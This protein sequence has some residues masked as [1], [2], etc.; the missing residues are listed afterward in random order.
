MAAKSKTATQGKAAA[1]G[2]VA[3]KVR[4]R[5]KGLQLTTAQAAA[6]N[7]AFN[8]TAQRL[9]NAARI[10]AFATG[11]R[12]YRLQAANSTVR[13]YNVYRANA[14]AAAVAAHAASMS[15]RQSK[16]AHQNAA[17]VQRIGADAFR[18]TTL[19]GRAQFAQA[20]V[21]A[22]AHAAVMHTITQKQ[23][24]AIETKF[25]NKVVKTAKKAAGRKRGRPKGTPLS[26][27]I[28]RAATR[29]GQQA[30]AK[31]PGTRGR[32]KG[33]G[34][35]G[36][37][38]AKAKA[39]NIKTNQA[40]AAS[41]K[42]AA[43][44]AAKTRTAP[45]NWAMAAAAHAQAMYSGHAA[46]NSPPSQKSL[47]DI[48]WVG[49]EITPNCVIVAIANHLLWAKQVRVDD[50]DLKELAME[51]PE[52]PTI[53]EVLWHC[54]KT[55]WPASHRGRLVDYREITDDLERE[56][57]VVGYDAMTDDGWQ[58]HCALSRPRSRVVSWGKERDRESLVE[59]AWELTWQ[60]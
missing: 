27:A 57:V 12:K 51:V 52:E 59:E 10:R 54:W 1:K 45:V 41:S 46:V 36:A 4:G 55:G 26:K 35:G 49:D 17:L 18:H 13:Q 39:Q 43:P 15:L 50:N 40:A 21:K 11:L 16:L 38:T 19:L 29:A 20:G 23:A 56:G 31:V 30:A 22:Y 42:K 9:A 60:L 37:T 25:L 5:P 32:P 24:V 44:K 2:K 14:Q 28:A 7:K 33:S 47:L 3:S 34:K 58:P 48:E 6:Y 53:E 8:A